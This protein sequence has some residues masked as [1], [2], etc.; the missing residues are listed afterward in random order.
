MVLALDAATSMAS[1]ALVQGG[2]LLAER[3]TR[4]RTGA[5]GRLLRD[6]DAVLADQG[7]ALADV[8]VIAVG[9]G[10][11]SFTGIRV[12]MA[13]ARTLAWAAGIPAVGVGTLEALTWSVAAS[14]PGR[15]VAPFVDA[16]KGEVYGGL[17]RSM[18]PEEAPAVVVPQRVGRA[19][20]VLAAVLAATGEPVLA[21]GDGVRA[22][23]DAFGAQPQLSV[24]PAVLDDPRGLAFA[25]LGG[26]AAAQGPRPLA[27]LQPVYLRR[28]EA[29]ISIGPPTG[30][31]VL[32]SRTDGR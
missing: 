21:V 2:V 24:A 27:E 8:A 10:P 4:V 30:R 25:I 15:L 9:V 18:G 7:V 23:P 19:P 22:W 26:L 32:E 3:A 16:R 13:T 14:Q 5:G 12:A 6:I 31:S 29:E 17:Y 11:G 28:S 1:V 20:D